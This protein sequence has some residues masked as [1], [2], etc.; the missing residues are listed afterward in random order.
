MRMIFLLRRLSIAAGL[1]LALS[2][3][4][5]ALAPLAA[6]EIL[7]ELTEDRTGAPIM[8]AFVVLLDES[9]RQVD[10]AFTDPAGRFRLVSPVAGRF[11]IGLDRIGYLSTRTEPIALA[12]GQRVLYRLSTVVE[13][14]ELDH[15]DVT[16]QEACKARPGEGE[17]VA[18][19]WEEA[20]KAL[21][22][23][24]FTQQMGLL[25]YSVV[26][27]DRRLDPITLAQRA[28]TTRRHDGVSRGSPYVA[29]PIEILERQGFARVEIDSIVYFGPDA[30]TLLSDWFAE[31]HCFRLEP[32]SE[33]PEWIGLAFEPADRQGAERRRTD[34]RHADIRGTLWLEAETARLQRLDYAYTG[35]P[36]VPGGVIATGRIEFEDLPTGEW[37]IRR[38]WIRMPLVRA[39]DESMYSHLTMDPSQRVPTILAI[40]EESGEVMEVMSHRGSAAPAAR[41]VAR[42]RRLP[43]E[44]IPLPGATAVD[45]PIATAA[46]REGDDRIAGRVLDAR[47]GVPLPGARVV[48]SWGERQ[49]MAV[50]TRADAAGRYELCGAPAGATVVVRASFPERSAEATVMAPTVAA[51]DLELRGDAAVVAPR[52]ASLLT[53]EAIADAASSETAA[54]VA[55]TVRD[56]ATGAPLAGAQ[57]AFPDEGTGTVADAGGRFRI[58]GLPPGV[59]RLTI[60]YLGYVSAETEIR[61]GPGAVYR[62][63]ARLVPSPIAVAAL[64]VTIPSAA[65]LQA[66][67]TGEARYVVRA[68][69]IPKSAAITIGDVIQRTMPGVRV[70][71]P[72]LCP[73]VFTRSGQVTL[74]VIDNQVFRDTC[75][76]NLVQPGDVETLEFLPSIAAATRYGRPGSGGVIVITTKHRGEPKE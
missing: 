59:R 45:G 65:E 44:P 18:Q 17:A 29:L 40:E 62:V 8:G 46:C 72:G 52:I 50:A 60:A 58:V 70:N 32:S 55:G 30:M 41:P 56:D 66:R 53:I 19:V 6:Q 21:N 27:R 73:Q 9:D 48:A 24:A 75:V 76:L 34:V 74:V 13:P 57:V 51:L 35:L 64:K 3:A 20:R 49:G 11:A 38:W 25:Q 71:Q 7:G 28:E 36:Q 69:D 68:E 15:I 63:D 4:P 16:V 33:K 42:A 10:A 43:S 39:P 14:V 37:M 54:E 1:A 67:G 5:L 22:A 47:T 12:A 61:A 2:P 31:T 23:T 26:A